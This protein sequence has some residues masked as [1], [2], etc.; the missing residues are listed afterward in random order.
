[1]TSARSVLPAGTV[2][3]LFSD[4]ERSTETGAALGDQR[5]AE[6]LVTHRTLLRRAFADHNGVEVGTEGDSFFVA[7]TRAADAAASAI[8]A[9][10][11]MEAHPWPAESRCGC[12]SACTPARRSSAKATTSVTTSTRQNESR[13]PVTADRSCCRRRHGTCSPDIFHPTRASP[14]SAPTASRTS[15]SRNTSSS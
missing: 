4:I 15:A 2:T 9:Q 10:R 13:T 14:T 3:F 8:D 11:A 6:H 5:W 7:F 12:A 1:M